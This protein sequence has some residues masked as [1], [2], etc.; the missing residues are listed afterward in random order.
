M[1]KRVPRP[2]PA[3]IVALLALC[4][5]VGGTAVAA[6]KLGKNAV[7][8]KNIKNGAVKESKLAG[9]AVTEGKIAASAVTEGKIASGAVSQGKLG[10]SAK[11]IWVE[12]ELGSNTAIKNQSGGVTITDGP[13]AGQAIVNFGTDITNRAIA[14]TP[15]INLGSVDVEYGRCVDI[16]CGASTDN[17]NAINV[18]TFASDTGTTVDSGFLAVALP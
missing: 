17:P 14:V 18:I 3:M 12:T 2:S 10:A 13:G 5:A 4:L 15:S 8:T 11:S 7:K 9:N 16:G 6:V 1:G